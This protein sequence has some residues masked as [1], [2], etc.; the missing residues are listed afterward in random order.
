[1]GVGCFA[2]LVLCIYELR[3]WLDV[4]IE[5]FWIR[6]GCGYD[7]FVCGDVSCGFVTLSFFHLFVPFLPSTN[8]TIITIY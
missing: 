8:Y 5:L 4:C 6:S 1:M 2:W 3:N 7:A